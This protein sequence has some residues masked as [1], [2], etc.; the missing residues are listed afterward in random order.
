MTNLNIVFLI[1]RELMVELQMRSFIHRINKLAVFSTCIN[2][3]TPEKHPMDLPMDD[4][5]IPEAKIAE[6]ATQLALIGDQFTLK[7]NCSEEISKSKWWLCG[8]VGKFVLRVCILLVRS[9]T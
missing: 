2:T 9:S 3:R 8:K 1:S 5:T 7:Y 4:T 6:I